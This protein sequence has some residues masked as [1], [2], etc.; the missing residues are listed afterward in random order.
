MAASLWG[1]AFEIKKTPPKKVIQKVNNPKDASKVVKKA[2]K[3]SSIPIQYRLDAIKTNVFK[4]LGRYADDTQVIRTREDL[5]SY[6]DKAIDNGE[7]AIDTETNNSLDPITCKLMGPCIYTPGLKNAYIPL[8]HIDVNTRKRL[9]N[10]LN[11]QDIKEEFE[12]LSETKIIMHNSKFDYQ[13]IKCTCELALKVYWDTLLGVRILDENEK[14]AKLKEQ[15][16]DKIDPTVEKYSIDHLFEDVEYAIVDPEVF[17]LYA[18]T[19]AFITYKLYKW[20]QAQFAKPGNE[21]LLNLFLNIEMPVMEVAA[22]MELTG[23]CIDKEYA[24]RLS[25]K[26]HGFIDDVDARIANQLEEYRDVIAEWR[27]TPEATYKA[28]KVNKKGETVLAKSKSEQLKDPPELTSP[29]QFAILLYDI[30]QVPVVDKKKPRG[31]GEEILE[32]IDNPLCGLVLEKRGLEKLVGTYIDKIP[33]CVN[34]SDGRLHAHFNQLGTDTGRF[35]SSDPN[36]QNIPSKNKEIRLMFVPSPGYVMVGG[37]FSQ[38]EPRL[39]SNYS[40]DENMMNAYRQGKDLY[41]T[42][43]TGIY[44][45]TYWD[46]MEH[47]EDGSPNPAGKKRRSSVKSLMLGRRMLCPSKIA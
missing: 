38:Q 16:R 39:L 27:K 1:E 35:S 8:N 9:D 37:D 19:D 17:A 46:N 43:A 28:S 10:Q 45:N 34:E 5:H 3:D 12:R 14:S 21:R 11:E 41:A 32:H 24:D 13:V 29:A 33:K 20:Q 15:Y 47:H 40:M 6:I 25:K 2:L 31:T 36:L 18:A 30:L 7:I 42:I 44:H 26:Y 4:I 23:V 22:E